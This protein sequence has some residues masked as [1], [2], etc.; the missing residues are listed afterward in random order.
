VYAYPTSVITPHIA[1]LT[2]E[3][4]AAIGDTTIA[5]V[6]EYLAG[7]ELTNRVRPPPA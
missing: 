4:L 7:A 5:N 6:H 1:F 2:A 3:A